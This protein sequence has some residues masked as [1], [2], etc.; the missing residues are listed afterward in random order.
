MAK[1]SGLGRGLDAIFIDNETKSGSEKLT[2]RLSQIEPNRGQPRTEFDRKA[3][4][5]LAESISIHGVLQP[6]IVRPVGDGFYRIIAGERRWRASKMAGLTEIPAIVVEA[7]EKKTAE[8]ALI[9][10]LQ[11]EDLN[12][13]EEAKAYQTLMS[14]HAM[15]QEEI[16]KRIGKSR[17][18]VANTLRLLDLPDEVL[19]L[20]GDKTLSAG[21]ARA[22]LGIADKSDLPF[23]VQRVTG[24]GL[25]VRS[26]EE[27][28]KTLN[29]KRR[30]EEKAAEAE[31]EGA[32]DVDY[33]KDLERRVA[34][35]LGRSFKLTRRRGVNVCEIAYSD[36]DDL[37]EIL[38]RLCGKDFFED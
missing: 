20:V 26:T 22:L 23:A 16:A 12:A 25:S 14:E 36:S 29:A 8:I 27:L 3:L 38:I 31:G 10:N 28:V 2:V 24:R 33:A 4:E 9:E 6:I 19:T 5:E 18:A 1:I 37:Q 17:S 13:V 21:H 34:A 15:T 32:P 11:R 7:D 30:E 35:S